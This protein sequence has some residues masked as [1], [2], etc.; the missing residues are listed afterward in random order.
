MKLRIQKD[1]LRLRLSKSEVARLHE[2]GSIE[3]TTHFDEG[4]LTYTIRKNPSGE[5]HAEL[6]EGTIMVQAPAEM[7]DR[8]ATSDETG[9]EA[10]AG[11]L[12]IVV[13]KDF[14][15]LNGPRPEDPPDTYPHPG[16]RA[17]KDSE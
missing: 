10:R 8:W 9:I 2:S 7:V 11:A 1:T 16:K 13:E 17:R 12:H 6:A 3:E 15:C 4:T 14:R 5:F